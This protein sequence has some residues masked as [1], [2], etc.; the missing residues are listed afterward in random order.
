MNE[1]GKAYLEQLNQLLITGLESNIPDITVFQDNIT[2]EEFQKMEGEYHHIIFETLG[3]S[4]PEDPKKIG[5]V[6][7]VIVRYYSQGR[8]DLDGM[9]LDIISILEKNKHIFK[10]STKEGIR[11][12]ET[13]HY[14]DEIVFTF[15]RAVKYEC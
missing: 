5:L 10:S 12:G 7:D 14:V 3:M 4:K 1:K 8:D 6:Q 13:D 9:M 15:S 11:K 2:E